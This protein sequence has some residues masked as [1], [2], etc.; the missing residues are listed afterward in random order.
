LPV[1]SANEIRD[2]KVAS[3][4][5]ILV[6]DDVRRIGAPIARLEVKELGKPMS[7]ISRKDC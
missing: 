7:P 2:G 5:K 6:G 4:P 3:G 1:T